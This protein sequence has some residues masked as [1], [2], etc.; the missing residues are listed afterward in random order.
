MNR[1]IIACLAV[2]SGIASAH[3]IVQQ[4]TEGNWTSY[5][6]KCESGQTRY[7]AENTE[8]FWARGKRYGNRSAAIAAA[9]KN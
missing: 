8:G 4:E 2:A 7:I 1:I 9:C 3:E 6:I 5:Q